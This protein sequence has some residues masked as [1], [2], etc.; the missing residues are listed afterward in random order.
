M[1]DH[2]TD[3][4]STHDPPR[5]PGEPAHGDAFARQ[6]DRV[7]AALDVVGF[8]VAWVD[9]FGEL[10]HLNAAATRLLATGA[11]DARQRGITWDAFRPAFA[12][13]APAT[14]S[15]LLRTGQVEIRQIELTDATG[16]RQQV[17]LEAHPPVGP[18]PDGSREQLLLLRPPADVAPLRRVPDLPA[19]TA[20]DEPAPDGVLLPGIDL[21]PR[22]REIVELLLRGYRVTSIAPRLFLSTHTIRN[23][24]KSV[25]RK[26]GVTSQAELIELARRRRAS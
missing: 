7:R 22:E 23:H 21:S 26:A 14:M 9:E 5:S 25:F 1:F 16:A 12:D 10:L 13:G 4:T 20:A 3:P 11:V 18:G 6:F 17:L 15:A 19:D 2:L 8:G 24:L